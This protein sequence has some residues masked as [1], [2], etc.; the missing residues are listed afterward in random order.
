MKK[1]STGLNENIAGLLCYA[2]GWISGLIFLFIE[3]E[4]SWVKFH[5]MQSIIT[6]ASLTV[7]YFVGSFI[8]VLGGVLGGLASLLSFV[9][10]IFLMVKAF[11]GTTFK[12]PFIGDLAE[13][14][15]GKI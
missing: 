14:H 11:A 9:L 15:V 3:K 12:L 1:S 5:A 2:F 13:K 8:P 10:W 4:S 6:F 7:I